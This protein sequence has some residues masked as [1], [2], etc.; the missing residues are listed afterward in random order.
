MG[1]TCSIVYENEPME[2]NTMQQP[3]RAMSNTFLNWKEMSTS[4]VQGVMITA[5]VLGI[6]VFTVRQGGSEELT[7]TMVF[8]TLILANIFLTLVNRS[9][10]YSFISSLRTKNSLLL[11][12]LLLTF[13]MLG[14]MLL[15]PS[16]A[17]FFHLSPL[18]MS[19]FMYCLGAAAIS[20]FWFEIVKR[21]RRKRPLTGN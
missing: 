8:T 16:I 4:I 21:Y 18:S 9:F 12:I 14:I 17:S 15:I 11:G 6:Y 2:K 10:Y 7:R 13:A 19:G 5:G 1:P 3:P 20:V